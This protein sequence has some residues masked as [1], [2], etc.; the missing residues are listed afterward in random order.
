MTVNIGVIGV[1]GVGNIGEDHVRR[2][3]IRTSGSRVAALSDVDAD[4]AHRVADRL[5]DAKI[6]ASGRDL[7]R[8]EGIDAVLVASSAP[9]H[10]DYVLSAIGEGKPVFVR[11]LW[12]QRKRPA[13]ASWR[14]RLR[15]AGDSC[16]WAS[17]V[18]TTPDTAR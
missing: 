15:A 5:R 4:L 16:R 13:F 3:S 11:N 10:E 8:D 12:Q 18:A 9:S 1:I 7:I 6:H 17:C 2:L 14:R